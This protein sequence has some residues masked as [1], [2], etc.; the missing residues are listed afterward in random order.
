MFYIIIYSKK[1][2]SKI[3]LKSFI[4]YFDMYDNCK[5]LWIGE[6]TEYSPTYVPPVNII[7]F[8]FFLDWK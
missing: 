5:E 6:A 8:I 2:I 7:H 4:T 1:Y 3:E